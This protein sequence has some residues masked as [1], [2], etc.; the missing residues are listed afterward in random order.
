MEA[1]KVSKVPWWATVNLVVA[2]LTILMILMLFGIMSS[3]FYKIFH[4][5]FGERGG[6][7]VIR[8]MYT[9]G[10]LYAFPV[11]IINLIVGIVSK[12]QSKKQDN[13]KLSRISIASIVFG[14]LN[15]LVGGGL[16]VFTIFFLTY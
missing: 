13:K 1:Q 15:T 16:L 6:E 10:M 9:F 11:G 7:K 5:I 12:V 14:S 8:G 4:V 2:I 3:D